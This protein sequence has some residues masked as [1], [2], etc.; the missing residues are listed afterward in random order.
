MSQ[1]D[2]DENQADEQAP[3][4]PEARPPRSRLDKSAIRAEDPRPRPVAGRAKP[5]GRKYAVGFAIIGIICVVVF[6]A[7]PGSKSSPPEHEETTPTSPAT[8]PPTTS[9]PSEP[10]TTR[11]A[12]PPQEITVSGSRTYNIDLP[13]ITEGEPGFAVNQYPIIPGSGNEQRFEAHP[14]PPLRV[15]TWDEGQPT[16]AGCSHAL[17]TSGV[18]D[19]TLHHT[20]QW[21]CGET[22]KN[23][24]A[25]IRYD[26]MEGSE[27]E[28]TYKFF[29]EVYIPGSS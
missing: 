28:P 2:P 17:A 29:V 10:T 18:F 9:T 20:G 13:S 27:T 5:S 24:V 19:V 4:A 11:L 1:D 8:P 25:L 14:S 23:Y 22:D 15:A 6:I 16:F 26:G 3:E 7:I 12:Y 21:L